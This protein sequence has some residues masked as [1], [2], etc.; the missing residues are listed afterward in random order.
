MAYRNNMDE[1][2]ANL[3]Q[4]ETH[5]LEAEREAAGRND[6][7]LGSTYPLASSTEAHADIAANL[8]ATIHPHLCERP[9]KI[10]C[11]EMKVRVGN[12]EGEAEAFYYPD[13]VVFPKPGHPMHD[14][15]L[16]PKLIIEIASPATRR[17]DH[18][19]KRLAYSA[20]TTLEEYA[21]IEQ[22]AQSVTVYRR[23]DDFEPRSCTAYSGLELE[24]IDLHLSFE[25]IYAGVDFPS[26]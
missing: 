23:S 22:Q 18:L 11:A 17:I 16:D 1:Q 9:E 19:E 10:H 26:A 3:W 21:V 5:Y 4:S 6:F 7:V 8:I 25:Q 15:R 20:I 14:F 12:A 2:S 24:S 13:I